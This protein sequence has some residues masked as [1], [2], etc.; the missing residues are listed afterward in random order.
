MIGVAHIVMVCQKTGRIFLICNYTPLTSPQ[1]E[2]SF[3]I[4]DYILKL[5]NLKFLRRA[6]V[7]VIPSFNI[8]MRFRFVLSIFDRP[9]WFS[10]SIFHF[11]P[12][13]T[14]SKK[15]SR[16]PSRPPLPVRPT[17][18]TPVNV[19]TTKQEIETIP[20]KRDVQKP[21]RP[22]PAPWLASTQTAT[23]VD[24]KAEKPDRPT[25]PKCRA[26]V[27]TWWKEIEYEKYSGLDEKRRPLQWFHGKIVVRILTN[28][29]MIV[30][31]K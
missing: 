12:L 29:V 20:V 6:Q 9:D 18:S 24:R 28:S 15:G 8:A 16:A 23:A 19:T 17:I 13:G 21:S 30:S 5:I 10:Y 2:S 3:K 14:Y 31:I 1:R 26:E 7:E 11:R 4:F 22:P 25:R 27:A